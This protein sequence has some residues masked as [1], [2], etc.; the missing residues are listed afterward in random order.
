MTPC[1]V[2]PAIFKPGSTVFKNQRKNKSMD[3]RLD[4]GNDGGDGFLSVSIRNLYNGRG[5]ALSFPI[6]GQRGKSKNMDA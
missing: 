1:P 5:H 4:F 2:T 6:E 3:S